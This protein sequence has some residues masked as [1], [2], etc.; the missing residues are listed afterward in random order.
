[1]I[2]S[3]WIVITSLLAVSALLKR[4]SVFIVAFS[5][6]L[7]VCVATMAMDVFSGYVLYSL[8]AVISYF[9]LRFIKDDFL[10]ALALGL[11]AGFYLIISGDYL[12]Y[13][14]TGKSD[15]IFYQYYFY[16]YA[17]LDIGIIALCSARL[18]NDDGFSVNNNRQYN[19][20]VGRVQCTTQHIQNL[21][22]GQRWKR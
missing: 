12:Y 7:C 8:C 14:L 1:M 3:P 11:H 21:E 15:T 19:S 9:M 18:D 5:Y 20:G 4:E 17:V 13:S 2:Y 6:A 10:P 22:K 16:I